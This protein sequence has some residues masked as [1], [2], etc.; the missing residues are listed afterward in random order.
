MPQNNK[1]NGDAKSVSERRRHL[2]QAV[3]A[4]ST[5]LIAG[6][7]TSDGGDGN[8]DGNGGNGSGDGGNGSDGGGDGGDGNDQK[9]PLSTTFAVAHWYSDNPNDLQYNPDV[10][11]SAP[12]AFD[13]LVHVTAHPEAESFFY[14]A[15]ATDWNY[16]TE[17]D[18]FSINLADSTWWHTGEQVTADDLKVNYQV[19]SAFR[20]SF[21][22]TIESY[23]VVDPKT[24]RLHLTGKFNPS[25]LNERL[26]SEAIDRPATHYTDF[27][28]QA[29][30]ASTKDEYSKIAEQ[31]VQHPIEDP[32]GNSLFKHVDYST[33]NIIAEVHSDHFSADKWEGIEE[34]KIFNAQSENQRWQR[35]LGGAADTMAATVP[36][37]TRSKLP[38]HAVEDYNQA[39]NMASFLI[40]GDSGPLG[41]RRVRQALA[42]I[43]DRKQLSENM[44]AKEFPPNPNLVGFSHSHETYLGKSFVESDITHYDKDLKKAAQLLEE[45]GLTKRNGTWRWE[46]KPWEPRFISHGFASFVAMA[47]TGESMLKQFGIKANYS[48]VEIANL[49]PRMDNGEYEIAVFFAGS[50]VSPYFAFRNDLMGQTGGIRGYPGAP[51]NG[52]VVEVP[53]VGEPDGELQERSPEELTDQLSMA[54]EESELRRL[55]QEL[56][57]IY[58]QTLPAIQ[59]SPRHVG[60]TLS[61]DEWQLVPEE[62]PRRGLGNPAVNYPIMNALTP[63]YE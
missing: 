39:F 3:A 44:G 12:M 46:G 35:F 63:K 7:S 55:R 9:V 29:A 59:I 52:G 21:R 30:D 54:T 5:G 36:P 14:P 40:N 41:D 16:D 24:L 50:G 20:S 34:V 60:H 19:E 37:E 1:V 48:T 58:N 26:L 8:G 17:G 31:I 32:I 38:D 25:V 43:F 4:G 22:N 53:P 15:L 56:A 28:E 57:W 33:Q 13:P 45:A 10:T 62:D 18:V 47:Q 2:L 49:F 61:T 27:A 6:C 11:S 51:D 23:E 42:Y